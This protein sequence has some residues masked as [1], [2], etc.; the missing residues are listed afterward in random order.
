VFACVC[1]EASTGIP[2][3]A[4]CVT[5][6]ILGGQNVPARRGTNAATV[7][8]RQVKTAESIEKEGRQGKAGAS[9]AG[10]QGGIC[11]SSQNERLC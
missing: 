5:K 2:D 7:H 10:G 8:S 11:P 1:P 3:D 6:I 9:F 4:N